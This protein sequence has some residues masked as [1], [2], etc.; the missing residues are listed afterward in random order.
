MKDKK[1]NIEITASE[2]EQ[3]FRSP[4]SE[5]IRKSGIQLSDF[6]D[7]PK[8]VIEC[9]YGTLDF[10][11]FIMMKWWELDSGWFPRT[12][13]IVYF[14]DW[15]YTTDTFMYICRSYEEIDYGKFC[16]STPELRDKFVETFKEKL[17]EGYRNGRS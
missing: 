7:F 11:R 10:L 9:N 15:D 17:Y 4:F 16:F 12:N 3:L 5:I 2:A 1:Y 6:I 14:L 13:N 8:S